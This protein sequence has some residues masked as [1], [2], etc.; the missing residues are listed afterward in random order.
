MFRK[1][2]RLFSPLNHSILPRWALVLMGIT[3]PQAAVAIPSPELVIGSVSS[4]S[5]VFAVGFAFVSGAAALLARKF[6]INLSGATRASGN[7]VMLCLLAVMILGGL[8]YWQYTSAQTAQVQRMQATL[9]RPAQFTGTKIKDET[10]KE[11]SFT[12]QIK[13]DLAMTTDELAALL[14][15]DPDQRPL[16]FDVRETGENAMGSLP[17][18]THVR[19]PDF[20]NSGQDLAGKQVVLFCHN[21]NRSSETCANLASMGID[22]KFVAGGIEK[23]IVEGRPF[24]DA[25]VE[26]LSDLRALPP[27]DNKETLL[28]S[29][30]FTALMQTGELQIVDTRYPKDF[31]AG[32]LPGAINIPVR[33]LPTAQLNRRI[34]AL[35]QKTTVA[36][37]YDRRSCF[38][39]QVLG[40]EMTQAG[41]PFAGRYTTPWD[42]FVPPAPKPHVAEWM[43]AQNTGVWQS[44]IQWLAGLMVSTSASLGVVGVILALALV[45]RILI[46]PIALKSERDQILTAQ[47]ADTLAALKTRLAG[48]PT[49]RARAI[50]QFYADKGLTPMRNLVALL[51]LPLMML[52]LSATE[53]MGKTLGTPLAWV[54]NIG[55]PDPTYV[56]P[57]LFALLAGVYLHWAV[58]KTKRSA[59]LWWVIGT[60][61][62]FGL[63]FQ[64]SFAGN[65]YLCVA[66]GLLLVQRAYVTGMLHRAMQGVQ[67]AWRRWTVQTRWAGVVPLAHSDAL[68]TA[69]NKSYRLSVMRNAGLPVPNGAVVC[70]DVI[71]RFK[72]MNGTQKEAFAAKVWT[73]IG[74][75]NCAVR[76]SASGEDGADKSFAGIF[77]SVLHVDATTL[78]AAL[79]T[80][81]AS[82]SSARAGSYAADAPQDNDGNILVQQMVDADYAG[83]L[84]TQDPTAPGL[85]MIELAQGTGDDLVSGRVT[86]ET[87]RFGR[88]TKRA[89][90]EEKPPFDLAPLITL[91]DEIEALFGGP[92]DIEWAYKDGAFY[93]L[94]SRD[95]TTLAIGTKA[96]QA[97]VSEWRRLFKAFHDAPKDG[98][99]LEQDEMSEVLPQPTPVSFTLMGQ[100]WAPGGSLDLACRALGVPYNVPEGKAGHLVNLFGKTFVDRQL[101]DQMAL[102]VTPSKAKQLRKAAKDMPAAIRTETLPRLHQFLNPWLATDFNKMP[103]DALQT[104]LQVFRLKLTQ[105]IYVEAEKIN[106]LAGFTMVEAQRFAAETPKAQDRL[107]HAELEHAPTGLMRKCAR[108]KG[109]EAKEEAL[110]VLGHRALFDYELS[111]PRYSEAPDLLWPLMKTLRPTPEKSVVE[112][113]LDDPIALALALQDLKEQA[114]HE[115]LWLVDLIRKT[116]LAMGSKSGLG[117]RIFHLEMEEV[118]TLNEDTVSALN[119]VAKRRQ[120]RAKVLKEVQPK[121]VELTLFDCEILSAP[122]LQHQ[123]LGDGDMIGTCVSG[124]TA[125]SGRVFVV[126]E[127]QATPE[128]AF[129]GFEDGD[130]IVCHM[131]NPEWLPY[132][133]RASAVLS[134]VGG[135]LSHMSIVAREHNLLMLVACKGLHQLQSQQDHVA[136]HLQGTIEVIP[137]E[138]E[139]LTLVG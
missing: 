124:S 25:S 34:A 27:Y 3:L 99:I 108:L 111:T 47:H 45:S 48:D 112:P 29:A 64:L 82:F 138:P 135:W 136:V 59:V 130:V 102:N 9:V 66:L 98:V 123:S 100:M 55:A 38:M 49:R 17:N 122:D 1:T 117:A 43:T 114:K 31:E 44:A 96:Q 131:V 62:L 35:E 94:Q 28:T 63:V 103:L 60:P 83:V 68:T 36:A 41:V 42:Y 89:V 26:T 4:L 85:L 79:E 105:D 23:W 101:K 53:E 80:V 139:V 65:V 5:Q 2:T 40:L 12:K 121:A 6:G 61:L 11:T 86:P 14:A 134:E 39:S 72:L 16:L 52:G 50:Q 22:C 20:M 132:I 91:G 70:S 119:V 69:G 104:A 67:Q 93:I 129:A 90:S 73:M 51:F 58:A 78:R 76:S 56:L 46:L 125:T 92:Q 21:G 87:H 30:D 75:Q 8:N 18:A 88:F 71:E 118:Q 127:A 19:Y 126:D 81:I 32:H 128:A 137:T 106:I 120:K 110:R 133:Q 7:V 74:Q 57:V 13:S 115:A 97:R 37:C 33:A 84:F 107:R 109:K 95:I 113:D 116:L 15:A 24:S 10:L 77:D 54:Q